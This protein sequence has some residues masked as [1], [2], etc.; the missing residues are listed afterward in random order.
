MQMPFPDDWDGQ[1]TCRWAVCWPD[2]PKWLAILSGLL[3]MPA[4]GRFWDFKTGNFLELRQAFLP[5]YLENF[6]LQEVIMA[7]GDTGLQEIAAALRSISVSLSAQATASAACCAG[8]TGAGGSGA[9]APPFDDIEIIDPG[10]GDPPLGFESWEQYFANKCAVATY[11]TDVIIG[12]VGRM[13]VI[14]LVGLTLVNLLPVLV[15][16]LLDP[17]P[18]DELAVLGAY[19]LTAL[20]AGAGALSAFEAVITAAREDL[21]C[22]LYNAASPEAAE[23][24][25]ETAFNDAWDGS[26]HASD[27][28]GFAVKGALGAMMGSNQTNRLFT[29]ETTL[30]LPEGDCSGCE[31]I[32][33]VWVGA[34]ETGQWDSSLD[35]IVT[36]VE[37]GVYEFTLQEFSGGY[38]G[39]VWADC[40]E[41]QGYWGFSVVSGSPAQHPNASYRPIWQTW[42][43]YA[44][45]SSW[46]SN[47][48]SNDTTP[49]SR[50]CNF[51]Q[52]ASANQLVIRL[53]FEHNVEP[54]H[55]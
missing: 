12:D 29:L 39:V 3:E 4:Q 37:D 28:W 52:V 21:I 16:L 23:A 38:F 46:G 17:I 13:R 53:T 35:G 11:I 8:S 42:E 30:E 48:W 41:A 31:P 9:T 51:I 44:E 1:S 22:A 26:S 36:F 10:E 43:D 15:G 19:L 32:I 2:S 34:S 49:A 25:F 14:N 47:N 54:C 20:A 27:P 55:A 5:I 33:P 18:G 40:V 7:C 45:I 6:T 50:P 24:A